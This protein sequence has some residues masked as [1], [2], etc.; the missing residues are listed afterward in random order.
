MGTT[1]TKAPTPPPTTSLPYDCQA[2][3][4]NWQMGWSDPKKAWCC[5]HG[6]KGC[7][8]PAKVCTL[9]GD[10]HVIGFD[11]VDDNKD[12]AVSFYGDGDFWLVRSSTVHIQARFEGTKYTE[13]LAATNR[14]V[15]GGPFL[16]GHKIEVGTRESEVLTV[17]GRSVIPSFPGSY[18]GHGFSV[19]YD[20]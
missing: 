20:G 4:S 6:G 8:L 3:V 2:G 19:H 1:T 18:S 10:P 5:A 14:I 13:R 12:R 15:V 11:Q 7:A 17:D 16:H 9:W